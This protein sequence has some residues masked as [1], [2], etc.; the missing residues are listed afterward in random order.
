M[1]RMKMDEPTS[2]LRPL[3]AYRHVVWDWNGTL[4][5][6]AWLC[7]DVMDGILRAHGLPGLTP[8]RYADLFDFP[9]R[10][11]YVRLGFDFARDP[12]EIVG[13]EF[14]AAYERR[15]LECGLQAG[16]R[17][18]L[19]ALR[20]AGIGQSVLS[21]YRHDTLDELLRHFDVRDRFAHVVGGDDIYAYGKREQ[22]VAWLLRSG[23]DAR[24]VLLVGD[25]VHDAE[26]AAAMGAD[27]RLIPCGHQ[28]RAKLASA[29]IPL[30]DSLRVLTP[31]R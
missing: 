9:V 24:E 31:G 17:E 26:V 5:D 4:F 29:G 11:Y 10:D 6:D 15:R 20:A 27:C 23:L 12:F 19:D 21:A 14:I 22:G 28:S 25:T 18:I 1:N 30:V 8:E 2:A 3:S 7:V 13:A 16:A